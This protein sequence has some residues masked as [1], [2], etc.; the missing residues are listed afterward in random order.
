MDIPYVALST[1]YFG[2]RSWFC[3]LDYKV[4]ILTEDSQHIFGFDFS[5]KLEHMAKRRNHRLCLRKFIYFLIPHNVDIECFR[6]RFVV[7]SRKKISRNMYHVTD[8]SY[9]FAL[10]N[11]PVVMYNNTV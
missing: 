6:F 2:I 10:E 7:L 5:K 3:Y 8:V 1:L 4:N 11:K 9:E